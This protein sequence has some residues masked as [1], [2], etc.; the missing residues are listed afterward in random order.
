FRR[1]IH[2][3]HRGAELTQDFTVFGYGK[4]RHNYNEVEYPCTIDRCVKCHTTTGRRVR[5][6][7]P[8]SDATTLVTPRPTHSSPRR[9]SPAPPRRPK[10]APRATA[11]VRTGQLIR[12]TPSKGDVDAS[13]FHRRNPAPPDRSRCTGVRRRAGTG[14]IVRRL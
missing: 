8:A 1:L 11:R 14:P 2:R 13:D 10:R 4:S 12:C 6:P 3:I 9:P 5:P 7:P